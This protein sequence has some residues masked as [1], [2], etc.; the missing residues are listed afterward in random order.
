MRLG[1]TP[2]LFAYPFGGRDNI[3]PASLRLVREAGF[4]CC[5]SACGGVNPPAA[6]PFH[7][8]RINVNEWFA[9][10]HQLGFQLVTGRV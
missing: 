1:V 10:P 4:E 5:L 7:L 6:D 8:N 2:D 3:S 9:T